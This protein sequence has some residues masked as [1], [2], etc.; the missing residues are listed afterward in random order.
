MSDEPKTGHEKR[1]YQPSSNDLTKG[2][3]VSQTVDVGSLRP[4]SNLGDAAV[5]PQNSNQPARAPVESKK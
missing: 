1:G 5:T 4:P 2:Y 3:G